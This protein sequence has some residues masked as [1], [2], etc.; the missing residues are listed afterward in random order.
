[1]SGVVSD[2]ATQRFLE[3]GEEVEVR[4][5]TGWIPSPA[6]TRRVDGSDSFMATCGIADQDLEACEVEFSGCTC[7]K[8][9]CGQLVAPPNSVVLYP[10]SGANTIFVFGQSATVQCDNGFR[11]AGSTNCAPSY[12]A[13]CDQT[14]NF[15]NPGCEPVV[16]EH[17]YS[18]DKLRLRLSNGFVSVAFGNGGETGVTALN[19][20][21]AT[22]CA[23]GFDPRLD[24]DGFALPNQTIAQCRGDCLL[25]NT[26]R[27]DPWTCDPYT[28]LSSDF[29]VIPERPKQVRARFG[30][31][32]LVTCEE[33]YRME[34]S[35]LIPG[36]ESLGGV[37]IM[38]HVTFPIPSG[39]DDA[40][41]SLT[42]YSITVSVPSGAW[43]AGVT[44]V[45]SITVFDFPSRR[46]GGTGALVAGPAV[47]FGPVGV[48]FSKPVI[49]TLPFDNFNQDFAN[50]DI[51]GCRYNMTG[52]YWILQDYPT[53]VANPVDRRLGTVQ[54]LVREFLPPYAASAVPI[55]I[56]VR[57]TPP[58]IIVPS[59]PPPRVVPPEEESNIAFLIGVCLGTFVGVL[60]CA[61]LYL[62]IFR[63]SYLQSKFGRKTEGD[64]EADGEVEGSEVVTAAPPKMETNGS[65][66]NGNSNGTNGKIKGKPVA[67]GD[68]VFQNAAGAS[69]IVAAT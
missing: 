46:R 30:D 22:S 35:V 31:G 4:C 20:N 61:G 16:C 37:N 38:A 43:P 60:L 19:Q 49:I 11:Q 50:M 9:E 40:M 28:P 42:R 51:V 36:L 65:T 1:M 44:A 58:P 69:D 14:G 8:V 66:T 62:S 25:T 54:I 13:R 63:T 5:Q 12:Q 53:T 67:A 27:C 7:V 6:C 52:K 41:L 68:V 64:S 10:A 21:V 18:I 15:F 2:T 57:P 55:V 33:G 17:A 34:N 39:P 59:P 56:P 3:Y 45:P 48:R 47:S 32:F 24:S 29:T 23:Y 26:A